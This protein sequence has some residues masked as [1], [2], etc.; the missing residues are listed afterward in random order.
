MHF[1]QPD[2]LFALD[3]A[4]DATLDG[5]PFGVIGFGPDGVVTRYNTV[6]A[7]GAGYSADRVVGRHL[8]LDVAPCM[9]N[10]LVAQ[11]FEDETTLDAQ[12]DYTFT[13][14][15]RPTPVRLRL[16]RDPAQVTRYV[17]VLRPSVA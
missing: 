17:I 9:H 14:R 13:F 15:V 2:L 6:E 11:R 12:L 5:L 7:Q 16:L 10:Y 4:S 1:D 3:V 8:F